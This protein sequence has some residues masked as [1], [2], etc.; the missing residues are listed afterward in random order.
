[1]S[2]FPGPSCPDLCVPLWLLTSRYCP[3]RIPRLFLWLRETFVYGRTF[4]V[5]FRTYIAFLASFGVAMA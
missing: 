1:M 4:L 5:S 3:S 2:Q